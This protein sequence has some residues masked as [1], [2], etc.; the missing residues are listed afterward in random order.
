M[1]TI[2]KR[3]EFDEE[4][5]G[6]LL[7]FMLRE[8]RLESVEV[9][10]E[11]KDHK[12]KVAGVFAVIFTLLLKTTPSLRVKAVQDMFDLLSHGQAEDFGKLLNIMDWQNYIFDVLHVQRSEAS[13]EEYVALEG[14]MCD[15]VNLLHVF[16]ATYAKSGWTTFEHTM[17]YVYW[18]SKRGD[19]DHVPLIRKMFVNIF[20]SFRS[21]ID[22]GKLRSFGSIQKLPLLNNFVHLVTMAEDF[23]FH[24]T[25]ESPLSKGKKV[26]LD[27]EGESSVKSV[28]S[29]GD[30]VADGVEDVVDD[31]SGDGQPNA[32]GEAGNGEKK[33]QR[34]VIISQDEVQDTRDKGSSDADSSKRENVSSKGKVEEHE[35]LEVSPAYI[36]KEGHI[37]ASSEDDLHS[38][39]SEHSPQSPFSPT[40]SVARHDPF[41]S[42][43]SGKKS[44]EHP[45][46]V[47]LGYSDELL[48]RD[49]NGVWEDTGIADA[50]L[51]AL[52][53]WDLLSVVEFDAFQPLR[54]VEAAD[55]LHDGGCLRIAIGMIR[56]M[57][58]ENPRKCAENA[59]RLER[60]LKQDED[61]EKERLRFSELWTVTGDLDESDEFHS[62]LLHVAYVALDILWYYQSKKHMDNVILMGKI[63]Q[64]IFRRRADVMQVP[65]RKLYANNP[66]LATVA[67][68]QFLMIV[69][70]RKVKRYLCHVLDKIA[71]P[72]IIV[73]HELLVKM[74]HNRKIQ[75]AKTAG[76]ILEYTREDMYNKENAQLVELMKLCAEYFEE[77]TERLVRVN[78]D[79]DEDERTVV[80]NWIRIRREVTDERGAWGTSDAATKR[81]VW[82]L[83][84]TTDR[85]LTRRRLIVDHDGTR[86][87]DASAL[88]DI[89]ENRVQSHEVDLD[90][91]SKVQTSQDTYEDILRV[92]EE[93]AALLEEPAEEVVLVDENE[94]IYSTTCQLVKGMEKHEGT[95]EITAMDMIF[96]PKHDLDG[97]M[98]AQAPTTTVQTMMWSTN[99]IEN[100]RLRR[101]RLVRSALEF[102]FDTRKSAFFNFPMKDRSK[103]VR[104][105]LSVRPKNLKA[106]FGMTPEAELKKSGLTELW[107]KR[108]I[109][110]FE[111]L[112]RL[113]DLAGRTYHD[114]SQ[115]FV[116]PWVIADYVSDRLNLQDD[117]VYR[118]LSKPIGA[119]N[120]DRREQ[121]VEK[122]EGMVG[123]PDM[124][125]FHYGSHY[126]S[127]G[128]VLYFLL[129][130]EPYTSYHI[131]LQSGK[132]DHADRLFHSMGSTWNNVCTSSADVKE[133]V[134][135]FYYLPDF[136]R[137]VNDLDMGVKQNK[138][139]LGDVVLPPWA[140]TPEEFVRINREALESDYVSE[141]LHEWIDLIFGYK[142]R[143]REAVDAVNVFHYLT[144]E[145]TVDLD[146]I[147][148]PL[149]RQSMEAQI[150]NF[151]Q[152]PSQLFFRP[153]AK[154]ARLDPMLSRPLLSSPELL[155]EYDPITID[156][157][158]IIAI[159]L[160]S[161]KLFLSLSRR[162]VS[163]QKFAVNT[164]GSG[165]PF[166]ISKDSSLSGKRALG[167]PFPQEFTPTTACFRVAFF[168][169]RDVVFTCGHWDMS[170]KS[171]TASNSALIQSIWQHR[172]IVTCLALGADGQTLVTGS[173]D[174]TVIVWNIVRSASSKYLV[175]KKARHVLFGHDDEVTDVAVNTDLDMVVSASKDGS[176]IIHSLVRG[177]Y[178]RSIYHSKRSPIDFVGITQEGHILIVSQTDNDLQ[179]FSLNGVQIA[180]RSVRSSVQSFAI[181]KDGRFVVVGLRDGAIEIL[182]FR[183]LATV[184]RIGH[185]E[186]YATSLE[187]T[188]DQR[189]IFAGMKSG[190]LRVFAFEHVRG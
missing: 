90:L 112:M 45:S 140:S 121:V 15:L 179:T 132:F 96:R 54:R 172:D 66:N 4:A 186:S 53:A 34:G 37:N 151:G 10:C 95:L 154:R 178:V 155:R 109:S 182:D 7:D 122:Y 63:V 162:V 173:K 14:A 148:D 62:R 12:I 13:H 70:N 30:D 77:E 75:C 181:T 139:I 137:N 56:H 103:V 107:R 127:A 26:H 89:R 2:L 21:D 83:D 143:G 82:K 88:R 35:A 81:V 144:Y 141:H 97:E 142:Q 188:P 108:A 110:N 84:R 36:V 93:E 44:E 59:E 102:H 1:L 166:S 174:T 32:N 52:Q 94:I 33:G 16:A 99:S 146:K 120:D 118:D 185:I 124:R 136:L 20:N 71:S 80:L 98:S 41:A 69:T 131:M 46:T 113:N 167:V 168:E 31:G 152:T 175:H 165:S 86:H 85:L 189:Y 126:S 161:D 57:L 74:A 42:P 134:P 64:N 73:K 117:K 169:G 79:I 65:L 111:Y 115:Y 150:E 92:E 180:S 39:T 17:G 119:L 9:K 164:S 55:H 130:L 27:D 157:D 187:V 170:F 23:M 106:T 101:Y 6:I 24:S 22:N 156:N 67:L 159:Q 40:P 125:P 135:E 87:E 158:A 25:R 50:V 38:P 47:I 3:F 163:V 91:L 116:F 171:S 48:H 8:S 78:L 160:L 147:T 138:E 29:D 183:T 18:F 51:Y 176:C 49:Q 5:Y 105:I 100:V 190:V 129:R 28:G 177:R 153:H 19:V 58:R 68:D 184:H 114:L 72:S 133:L 123:D 128:V 11:E 76:D 43:S 104:K 61:A 60:I 145:G 149:L